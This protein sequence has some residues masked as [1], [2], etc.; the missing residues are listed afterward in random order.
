MRSRV[1]LYKTIENDASCNTAKYFRIVPIYTVKQ[2]KSRSLKTFA[3]DLPDRV[4]DFD[5]F[6]VQ[7]H[8]LD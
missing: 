4:F 5:I 8:A 7:I 3:T 2:N 1:P 6:G